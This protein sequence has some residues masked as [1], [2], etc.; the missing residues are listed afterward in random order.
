MAWSEEG[1]VWGWGWVLQRAGL[2]P[3]TT[4]DMRVLVL[5]KEARA[6]RRGHGVSTRERTAA[7]QICLGQVVGGG[8]GG[9]P[10]PQHLLSLRDIFLP[11]RRGQPGPPGSEDPSLHI[12]RGCTAPGAATPNSPG[13]NHLQALGGAPSPKASWEQDFAHPCVSHSLR[14]QGK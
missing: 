6:T 2:P 11:Y 1:C 13:R 8:L 9:T 10:E 5:D 7:G 12:P 3:P 4:A 14:I